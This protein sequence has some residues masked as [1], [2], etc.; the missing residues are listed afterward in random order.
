L[1]PLVPYKVSS[2]PVFLGHI[3]PIQPNGSFRESVLTAPAAP[4]QIENES[5]FTD[6]VKKWQTGCVL[7]LP[8]CIVS[9]L[10]GAPALMTPL[11]TP[12]HG[13]ILFA[14]PPQSPSSSPATASAS[15][16]ISTHSLILK[17]EK[18]ASSYLSRHYS[19]VCPPTSI[20]SQRPV[21]IWYV[22]SLRTFQV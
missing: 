3:I 8:P 12:R 5:P 1:Y 6:K 13:R 4:C 11:G 2:I 14:P 7:K 19:D 22:S 20:N 17:E 9:H 16:L 10:P 18:T 15:N 21:G